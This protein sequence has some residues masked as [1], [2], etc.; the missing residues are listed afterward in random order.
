MKMN[1]GGVPKVTGKNKRIYTGPAKPT[2]PNKHVAP[3]TSIP[4]T[5]ARMK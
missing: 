2:N 5:V 1:K 4:S 3:N